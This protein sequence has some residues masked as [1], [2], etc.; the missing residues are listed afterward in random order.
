MTKYIS[1]NDTNKLIRKAL[2]EAFPGVKFSVRGKSYSGGASTDI[3]WTNGPTQDQVDP[4]AQQFRGAY[5]D[6]MIDMQSSVYH[7]V[8]G[9][10]VR[11]GADY[12]FCQRHHSPEFVENLEAAW[13]TMTS[14]DRCAFLETV[15]YSEHCVPGD[16]SH[17]IDR[18]NFERLAHH[19]PA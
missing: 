4:I 15:G 10:Q 17:Y 19:I 18:P 11:Y 1:L 3:R 7:E 9:E 8:D 12:I 5:F 14:G 13:G 2:K 6:G 16:F